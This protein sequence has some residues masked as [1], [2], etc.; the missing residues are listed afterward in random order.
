MSNP[1]FESS[2]RDLHEEL[3]GT[4]KD[5]MD[6]QIVGAVIGASFKIN[7]AGRDFITSRSTLRVAAGKLGFKIVT[8]T[9]KDNELWALR[10][11]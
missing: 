5:H 10:V 2:W 9:G 3:D 8:K 11:S 4:F 7:R 1:F 6:C